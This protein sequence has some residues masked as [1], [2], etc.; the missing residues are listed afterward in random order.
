VAA[1]RQRSGGLRVDSEKEI[2]MPY[3][4]PDEPTNRPDPIIK[5]GHK[6]PDQR[7]VDRSYIPIAWAVTAILA[8]AAVAAVTT[9]ESDK[10]VDR[11]VVQQ[12]K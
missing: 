6:A 3:E 2:L 4:Y 9:N 11:S 5:D 10:Q 8:L 1:A 12:N 7:K